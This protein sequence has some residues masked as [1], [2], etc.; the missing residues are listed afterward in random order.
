MTMKIDGHGSTSMELRYYSGYYQHATLCT[1]FQTFKLE[2]GGRQSEEA[3]VEWASNHLEL[4]SWFLPRFP[5][6]FFLTGFLWH[7]FF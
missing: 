5:V 6:L 2:F 7:V 3:F 4:E 1:S